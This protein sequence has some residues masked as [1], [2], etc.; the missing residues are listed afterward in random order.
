[1][2]RKDVSSLEVTKIKKKLQSIAIVPKL[3][4][5]KFETYTSSQTS[6]AHGANISLFQVPKVQKNM[7]DYLLPKFSFR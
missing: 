6:A 7:Y 1:M 3:E 2:V 5:P 4:L